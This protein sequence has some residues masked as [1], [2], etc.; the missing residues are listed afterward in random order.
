[1][2][3]GIVAR[4]QS[5]R[6]GRKRHKSSSTMVTMFDP[7]VTVWVLDFIAKEVKSH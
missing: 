6:S 2:K 5:E 1:M 3:E 4:A 7:L